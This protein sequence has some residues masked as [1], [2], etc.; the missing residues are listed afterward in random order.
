MKQ[1]STSPMDAEARPLAIAIT[2]IAGESLIGLVA[3]A[4][5]ENVLGST[6]IVLEP[7]GLSLLHPG[8]LG[9]HI[10][11]GAPLL[12]QQ[13][14][15]S[16]GDVAS[17]C[18]PYLSSREE[19]ME[20]RWG[21]GSL[22]RPYVHVQRRRISPES[23]ER[24]P[25]HR[26]DWM[27]LLLSY[28]P[29]SLELLIDRCP[30]CNNPLGWRRAWG[31]GNCDQFECRQ[32][33][34]H[35]SGERLPDEFA[36]DYRWFAGLISA[37]P[38]TRSSAVGQLH[39]DLQRLPPLELI[40][41]VVHAGATI[42]A[43]RFVAHRAT[44]AKVPPL[45][46]ATTI[47]RGAQLLR[48]WPQRLRAETAAEF[49]RLFISSPG[50]ARSFQHAVRRLGLPRN[51]RPEQMALV[52]RALP[53]AFENV[54]TALGGLRKPVVNGARVCKITGISTGQLRV[55]RDAN[56]IG[57]RTT[58]D[59]PRV[60]AF[61]DLAEAEEFN[62]LLR[63]AMPASRLE[64]RLGTPR[65]ATEQLICL[66]AIEQATD[67]RVKLLHPGIR[68]RRESM[69]GFVEDLVARARRKAPD[70]C[71]VPLGTAMRV[72]GGRMKPWGHVLTAIRDGSLT[73]WQ[74]SGPKF[75][76]AVLVRPED[77]ERFKA[78]EFDSSNWP[79]FEFDTVMTQVDAMDVLNIDP[80][81]MR[82]VVAAGDLVFRPSGVA[83]V[84]SRSVVLDMAARTIAASEA[85]TR[86]GESP[87]VMYRTMLRYPKVRS[88]SVGWLR[89]DFDACIP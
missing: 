10:G 12:A 31:I 48:D 71:A 27:N 2:P 35:P 4:T 76:R 88:C 64:Q 7:I 56:L 57:H 36:D 26:S 39:A 89:A 67:P 41:L 40:N 52:R 53:E 79:E 47:A 82:R 25:H 83:L 45:K 32:L 29:E 17:R 16:V 81:Q 30:V 72:V 58:A 73:C 75:V 46:L 77:I 61:Y 24:S 20:V 28:C 55:L 51:A 42:R 14:G 19:S 68:L 38:M 84:T 62:S 13:L 86:L 70:P 60:Q 50:E 80:D 33:V 59:G 87:N 21:S 54:G 78:I 66:G 74:D 3:R 34:R 11:P 8:A 23:I 37:D 1:F 6:R 5:R 85:A 43:D 49:D 18:H 15:C 22:W 69:E 44:I 9:Q 63:S 65:Y